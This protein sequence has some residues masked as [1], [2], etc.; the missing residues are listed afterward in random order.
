MNRLNAIAKGLKDDGDTRSMDQLRADLYIALLLSRPTTPPA[1]T[2]PDDSAARSRDHPISSPIRLWARRF[3]AASS[4]PGHR[5]TWHH[6][7]HP[8]HPEPQNE[9]QRSGR[10]RMTLGPSDSEKSGSRS[11]RPWDDH[12][13]DPDDPGPAEPARG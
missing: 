5:R 11:N 4:R 2:S 12:A 13:P 6:A 9:V 7:E 1:P 10:S 8:G 3:A